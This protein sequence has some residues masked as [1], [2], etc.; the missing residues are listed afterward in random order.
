MLLDTYAWIEFFL[1]SEKGKKVREIIESSKCFTSI[2][3][4]AEISEWCMKNNRDIE[5]RFSIVKKNSVILDIDEDIA[6]LS[7]IMNFHNKK[8]VKNIGMMDSI[9]LATGAIYELKIVTGDEH[10]KKFE[11]V[12]ML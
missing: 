1:G 6:K 11:N 8:K 7:G 5:E 12:I 3:S 10:F 9:V 2:I 4:L